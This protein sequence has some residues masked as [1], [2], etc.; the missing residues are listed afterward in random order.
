MVVIPAGSFTMGSPPTEVGRQESEG[1][2]LTVK[3]AK[4]FA[5]GK[6]PVTVDEF[7]AFIRETGYDAGSKCWILN[8]NMRW[9]ETEGMSWRETG[10][11]RTGSHPISC[12]TWDDAQAYV[13]WLSERT[14]QVYRLLS[15]SEWEYATRARVTPG[16]YPRFFFGESEKDICEYANSADETF[17]NLFPGT[18]GWPPNLCADGFAYTSPVGHFKPNAFGLYDMVGNVLTWV[19]D[20][21]T[22]NL[23]STPDDGSPVNSSDCQLRARRGGSWYNFP[24]FLRSAQRWGIAASNRG[25][26]HGFRVA[27]TLSP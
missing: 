23:T 15:E 5:V 3:I 26:D 8:K 13:K 1:P 11:P 16:T 17:K 25:F 27:R 18:T 24:R 2:Q 14:G 10:F 12:V 7:A 21:Y 6:Y 19:Q 9:E 20:C 22:D 4:P